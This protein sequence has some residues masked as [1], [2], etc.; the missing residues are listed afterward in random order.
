MSFITESILKNNKFSNDDLLTLAQFAIALYIK[1]DCRHMNNVLQ[2]LFSTCIEKALHEHNESDIT[3]YAQELYS[4]YEAHLVNLIRDLF[5]SPETQIMRK[6]YTYL[7][8]KLYRSFCGKV[9]DVI[10]YPSK[11]E[12]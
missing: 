8:F 5:F 4:K 3:K 12:W 10:K 6:I 7:T 11:N 9:D 1:F 2:Q